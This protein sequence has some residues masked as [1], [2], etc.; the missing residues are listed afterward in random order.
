[1]SLWAGSWYVSFVELLFIIQVFDDILFV[2]FQII[3]TTMNFFRNALSSVRSLNFLKNPAA[4]LH[5][6]VARSSIWSP[7]FASK[8]DMFLNPAVSMLNHSRGM[9]YKHN[10]KKRCRHCYIIY[11]DGR[12]FNYCKVKPRHNHGSIVARDTSRLIVTHMT[13]GKR[14]W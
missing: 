9:K 8:P 7:S 14:A 5:S 13:W 6:S 11:K 3:P 4:H 10:V 1:M 12:T 2:I